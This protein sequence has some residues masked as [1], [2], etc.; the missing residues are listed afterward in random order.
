MV[1]FEQG[2]S[3]LW[4][5]PIYVVIFF[6]GVALSEGV[7]GNGDWGIL[8]MPAF[9][10][11]ML[12]CELRSGVAL[13]SWWRAAHIKGSRKYRLIIAWHMAAVVLLSLVSCFAIYSSSPVP[14]R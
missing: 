12:L 10:A 7:L 8:T 5:F 4:L 14:H 2:K 1:Q 6:G 13:D 3:Y 11:F 9:V